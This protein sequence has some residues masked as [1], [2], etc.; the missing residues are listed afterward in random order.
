MTERS[1]G[2]LFLILAIFPLTSLAGEESVDPG[3]AYSVEDG[4]DTGKGTGLTLS[5]A[6]SLGL[7]NNYAVRS[8]YLDRVAQKFDLSVAE[9]R[10]TPKLQISGS[11][12]VGQREDGRYQER[13]VSPEATLLT[14]LGTRFSL[15]WTKYDTSS[16]GENGGYHNDGA[17]ITVIQPLLRGAGRDVTTAPR[18]IARLEEQINRLSLKETI[19]D[20][21]TRIIL[22]YRELL[23]AQ[24]QLELSRNSLDRTRQLLDINNALIKAGRMAPA[25]VVQTQAD[26]AMQELSLQNAK[27]DVYSRRLDLLRLLSLNLRTKIYAADRPDVHHIVVNV[28]EALEQAEARQPEYLS[29]LIAIREAEINLT[30]AKNNQRWDVSLIGGLSQQRYR[31]TGYSGSDRSRENYIGVQVDIPLN[32][33]SRKQD[34]VRAKVD[35]QKQQLRLEDIRAGLEQDVFNGVRDTEVR[36]KEYTLATRARELSLQKVE[37]ERKKLQAGRSSNFQVL[38][39]ETD[40]RNTENAR[41]A[42]LIAYL[43]AQ[44]ELDNTLGTTLESWDITLND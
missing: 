36:W 32:D 7:R 33:K 27:N 20:T 18:T 34:E 31:A 42:A 22:A 21:V 13:N 24:E 9:D 15:G 40:L 11:Q 10:F 30:V 12:I 4:S 5:D 39:Y 43:N 1:A 17:S 19:S 8:A 26:V 28:K 23:L 14:T 37:I 16:D 2:F 35:V 41:L 3:R 6:V 38:S 25:D 29:Q 44:A